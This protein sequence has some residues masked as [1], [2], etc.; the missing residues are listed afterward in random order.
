MLFTKEQLFPGLWSVTDI[1]G[2][3]SFLAVGR[4]RAALIDTGIGLGS[5][6][7]YIRGITQL[8]LTVIGTHGHLDHL[9][10]SAEF[11]EVLLDRRD[12]DLA[13]GHQSGS[14][15]YDYAKGLYTAMH[16]EE[17]WRFE[18]SDFMPV[19]TAPYTPLKGNDVFD[20]GGI[21][22]RMLDLPGHTQGSKAVLFEELRTVLLGDAC[23]PGVFLF[24]EEASCVEQYMLDLRAFKEK[25]DSLYDRVLV[26]HGGP[27]VDKA[28]V[29]NVI[30]IG[31]AIMDGTDDHD[32][33]FLHGSSAC[34]AKRTGAFGRRL[35]GGLGNI[36]YNPEKIFIHK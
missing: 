7:D 30:A 18:E 33:V 24:G 27:F 19:R 23:N 22:V 26:S 36:V 35:D 3:R 12:F 21:T 17:E 9:G 5:L 11:D 10:G 4:E 14:K 31:Q 29:D 32:P 13:Y 8:P 15:R 2:T 28:I 1:A 16:P 25:Y 20:L 34:N 6:K